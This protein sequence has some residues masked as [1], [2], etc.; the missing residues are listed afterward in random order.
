MESIYLDYA[1]ATPA[2]KDVIKAMEPYFHEKFGNS[3]SLH[4]FGQKAHKALD[5]SR[6]TVAKELNASFREIIFTG[7]A[8]EAN[9]TVIKG[10]VAKSDIKN[11]RIIISSIEH[12][13][14]SETA[15][16]LERNGVEIIKLQV[17]KDGFVN[18]EDLKEALNEQTI[19]VS[20][21][22]ASNVIGSIQ[23]IAEIAKIIKEFREKSG[24]VYPLY[25]TDAVQ[26]FIF[27][28]IDVKELGIDSLTLSGQKIY[29]PKGVGVLYLKEEW[30]PKVAPLITGGLQEFGFRAGTV[31]VP[32]IVGFKKAV[33]LI[34]ENRDKER[35]RITELRDEF[36][37][38]LK[39]GIPNIELNGSYENRLPNNLHI[40]F[41]GKDAGELLIAF[42]EVGIAVST[43]SACS[44]R[45][46]KVAQAV[47]ALGVSE[48]R[49][50]ESIRFTLGYPTTKEEI[51]EAV[52][53]IKKV[54]A[55]H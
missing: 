34:S 22:Y 1:A 43:G 25:H 17:S 41:P 24:S 44:A 3:G 26:A 6:E 55:S 27:F 29:G 33:E 7:S 53:R 30:M 54:L 37:R 46:V 20:I 15:E 42:D 4:I 48:E 16:E 2:D 28:K 52:S 13:S 49:A 19:L 36:W 5:A 31:N 39:E 35:V 21:I 47:L 10:V 38:G 32:T 12:E 9:N 11:P 18:P 50:K 45:A 51:N 40:Y 8:T 23:P 14:I